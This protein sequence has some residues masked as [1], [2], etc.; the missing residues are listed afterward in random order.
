[1]SH[2]Q[3]EQYHY[4]GLSSKHK[5]THSE[6]T[7]PQSKEEDA[8]KRRLYEILDGVHKNTPS[9]LITIVVSD[10]EEL[11]SLIFYW[12]W[13]IGIKFRRSNKGPSHV[14]VSN[15]DSQSP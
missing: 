14:I 1:M 11:Q 5:Q 3:R 2:R 12:A 4:H 13:S 9:N 6:D 8:A 15:N 10:R 7:E